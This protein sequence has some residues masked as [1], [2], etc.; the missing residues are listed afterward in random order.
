MAGFNPHGGKK[1]PKAP[2]FIQTLLNLGRGARAAVDP[3]FA[4]DEYT[5]Q[6]EQQNRQRFTNPG[7]TVNPLAGDPTGRY[8]PPTMQKN[9]IGSGDIG[10]D[11][12]G[13]EAR[14]LAS[15][16]APK[17]FP[18]TPQGQFDRYFGGSTEMDPYFGAA[19]RGAGAPKNLAAMEALAGQEK[20]PVGTPLATYYRA[21]SAAGRGNMDELVE[22]MGYK[23]SLA[24]W[25]KANPMLAQREFNKR[26]PAGA[27]TIGPTPLAL[28]ADESLKGVTKFFP[29]AEPEGFAPGVANPV[30]PTQKEGEYG[31]TQGEKVDFFRGADNLRAFQAAKT[32]GS[33]MPKLPTTGQK[34]D[35]FLLNLF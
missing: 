34:V 9:F 27:P 16:Y 28:Q 8:I 2:D 5:R 20:A 21:Q 4:A 31:M 30:P 35:A 23:G 14:A 7:S 10:G 32:S 1:G 11:G 15:Q 18:L 22:A 33:G 6:W 26:F 25:A 17:P 13:D 29:G 3:N 19:S 24:E 12:R